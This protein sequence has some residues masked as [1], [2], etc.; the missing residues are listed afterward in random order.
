MAKA[1]KD[2]KKSVAELLKIREELCPKVGDG[3]HQAAF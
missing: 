1:F 2:I 3:S